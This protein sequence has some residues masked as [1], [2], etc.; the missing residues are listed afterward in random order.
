MIE[1]HLDIYIR[2]QINVTLLS[3]KQNK[4]AVTNF[5]QTS[6]EK[7][8]MIFRIK[9]QQNIIMHGAARN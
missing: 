5:A 6:V 4:I 7:E 1:L 9:Q 2:L 8:Q 3:L